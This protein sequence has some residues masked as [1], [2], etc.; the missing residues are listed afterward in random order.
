MFD[1]PSEIVHNPMINLFEYLKPYFFAIIVTGIISFFSLY[2]GTLIR[3][4]SVS[5]G[6]ETSKKLIIVCSLCLAIAV[7]AVT[8]FRFSSEIMSAPTGFGDL[9]YDPISLSIL[10][11]SVMIIGVITSLGFSIKGRDVNNENFTKSEMMELPSEESNYDIFRY[12]IFNKK[13]EDSNYKQRLYEIQRNITDSFAEIET[14]LHK[15]YIIDD[16]SIIK[17]VDQE[18]AKA[19]LKSE[20]VR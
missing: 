14:I 10:Y 2:T 15:L 13:L 6:K 19:K 11:T 18:F 5:S 1:T 4:S 12:E 20:Q 9:N 8:F 3:R 7:S 16:P 17:I